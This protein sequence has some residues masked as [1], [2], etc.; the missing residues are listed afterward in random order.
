MLF[1]TREVANEEV[2]RE[3]DEEILQILQKLSRKCA[4]Q[5]AAD[6]FRGLDAALGH[7]R[8]V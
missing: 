4:P 7:Q 3:F 1:F 6:S 2:G 5:G 8:V